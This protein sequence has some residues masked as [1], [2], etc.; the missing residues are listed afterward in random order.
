MCSQFESNRPHLW[1][2]SGHVNPDLRSIRVDGSEKGDP[3]LRSVP[4][5]PTASADRSPPGRSGLKTNSGRIDRFVSRFGLNRP[6]LWIGSAKSDPDLQSVRA[7]PTASGDRFKQ[8][9]LRFAVASGP[10]PPLMWIGSGRG[11]R[12]LRSIQAARNASVG[13]FG[14]N[15]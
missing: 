12:Y 4:T 11:E 8:R 10:N 2:R 9:R 15:R 13:R 1:V 7:E 6:Y 5:E 3:D 14:L